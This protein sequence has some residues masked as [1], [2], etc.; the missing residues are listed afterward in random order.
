MPVDVELAVGADAHQPVEA[1]RPGGMEGLSDADAGDLG[2]L[3]PA[4]AP[5]A[6]L[7]AEE[8][9]ALVERLGEIGAGQRVALFADLAPGV[10][11]VD[12]ADRD[13]VEPQLARR[14]VDQRLD[15]RRGLVLAGP[16]LRA[17]RRGIGQNRDSAP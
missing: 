16:A 13:A 3:A 14:L 6:L 12:A 1:G 4:A 10:G 15:C 11:R 5:F 7:P 8:L 2:I 17:A 9:G